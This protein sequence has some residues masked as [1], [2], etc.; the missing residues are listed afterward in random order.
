MFAMQS[1]TLHVELKRFINVY[2]AT[3]TVYVQF[4]PDNNVKI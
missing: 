4:E 1:L 2:R 3:K